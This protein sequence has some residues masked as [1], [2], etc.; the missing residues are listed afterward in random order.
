VAPEAEPPEQEGS[1]PQ[2]KIRHTDGGEQVVTAARAAIDG[3]IT[4]FESPSGGNWQVIHQVPTTE[5]EA[6]QRRVVEAS[7]M[8]RWI[9]EKPKQVTSSRIWS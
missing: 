1:L 5:V 2:F 7:G 3:L 9:T 4:I 6:V 8:A